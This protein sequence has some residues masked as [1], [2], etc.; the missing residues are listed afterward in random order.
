MSQKIR[1][2]AVVL[3]VALATAL[4][5]PFA[6]RVFADSADIVG[7]PLPRP[8]APF[9]HE[10]LVQHAKYLA[11]RAYEPV[12]PTSER[13]AALS[14]DQH[15]AIRFKSD[16]SLPLSPNDGVTAQLLPPGRALNNP[17]RINLIE[18][19]KVV[20]VPFDPAFF[21]LGDAA[22]DNL[23]EVGGD[24][25]GFRLHS[26]LN[27]PDTLDE[28]LVFQGASYF[29][30]IAKGHVYGLSARGLAIDIGEESGEE[31]PVFTD[32][33][34]QRNAEVGQPVTLYALM[35]SPGITGI[36][37][38][39]VMPGMT[40]DMDVS[41]VLFPRRDLSNFGLAPLTSM[42]L[43]D[44]TNRHR[45]NDFRSGAHD[46]DGLAINNGAGEWLWR[47]LA[48]PLGVQESAFVDRNPRA[49]GLIQRSR[50]FE[51]FGDLSLDY[52]DRPSAWV[53]PHGDWGKGS[54]TLVEL[55]T[56]TETFDNIVAYWRPAA[57]FLKGERYEFSY[58]L[59]WR[60]RAPITNGLLKV[61]NTRIGARPE[62]GKLIAIDFA[63]PAP[64]EGSVKDLNIDTFVPQVF[65]S[66]GIVQFP[67]LESNPHTGG[68]RLTFQFDP[69]E[70]SSS[71]F[72][73]VLRED[74][75]QVSEKWLYRWTRQ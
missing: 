5:I 47:P 56:E 58:T 65:T 68:V 15:R 48:N 63:R 17:V 25:S 16:L 71:E 30:A 46:S 62:G 57:P 2:I 70:E 54:V 8:M 20:P 39:K 4:S 10:S 44:E 33:W 34:L 9:T 72:R 37:T 53:T 27:S 43:F 6:Q 31:F 1:N 61:I 60:D 21:S 51:D 29:R 64:V 40:T 18:D 14:F 55:P 66:K 7:T 19:G 73:I 41:A 74:G 13:W 26:T 32:F 52:N 59:S 22:P 36:Y 38:F 49:F 11:E 50:D 67:V 3:A 69:Q 24:Y 12:T 28:F 23:A 45:F 42:F 35:D 75:K